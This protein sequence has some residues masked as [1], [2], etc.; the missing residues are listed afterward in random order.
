MHVTIAISTRHRLSDLALLL[1]CL[2]RQEVARDQSFEVLVVDNDPDGSARQT[3]ASAS[4]GACGRLRYVI[5]DVPGIAAARN[6]ALDEALGDA[7]GFVDNDERPGIT[8]LARLVECMAAC[9][10]DLVLG[11]VVPTYDAGVAGWVVDTGVFERRRLQTGQ[12]VGLPD[13]GAGNMILSLG[14][15]NRQQPRLRFDPRLGL[16]GGEDILF[17]T[18]ALESGCERRGV[19]KPRSMSAFRGTARRHDICAGAGTRSVIRAAGLPRSGTAGPAR[20][21]NS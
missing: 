10:A 4:P 1:N 7:I 17:F 5:E 18:W 14:W 8:W 19:T 11:P 6:R 21:G 9:G 12:A 15:L 16:S 3:V 2:A 13:M 20:C